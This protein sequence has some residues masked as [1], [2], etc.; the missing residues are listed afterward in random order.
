MDIREIVEKLEHDIVEIHA[1]RSVLEEEFDNRMKFL[2][3]EITRLSFKLSE[4]E[5]MLSEFEVK[6]VL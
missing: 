6:G 5:A 4:K 2:Q 1:E 3:S